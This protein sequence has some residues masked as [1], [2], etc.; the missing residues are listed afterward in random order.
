L[1]LFTY[2]WSQCCHSLDI[3]RETRWIRDR[4]KGKKKKKGIERKAKKEAKRKRKRNRK[5]KKNE[6]N[7]KKG[8]NCIVERKLV[9]KGLTMCNTKLLWTICFFWGYLFFIVELSTEVKRYID[10]LARACSPINNIFS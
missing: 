3:E 1:L 8:G 5:K 10:E 7:K 9:G 6:G 4:G 2:T